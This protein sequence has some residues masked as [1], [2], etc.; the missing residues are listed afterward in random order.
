M[1]IEQAI[2]DNT[3]AIREL[4]KV[5]TAAPVTANQKVEPQAPKAEAPK[6]AATVE[7]GS[8]EA[9]SAAG[10]APAATTDEPITR[11]SAKD[12]AKQLNV[13]DSK[14]LKEVLT[15]FGAPNFAAVKDEQLAEFVKLA[16]A[17]L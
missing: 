6:P 7:A 9:S 11:D 5:L 2:A 17:A 12:I 13:K 8:T 16:K 10:S 4:I 1:S 14:K 3:A 15:T